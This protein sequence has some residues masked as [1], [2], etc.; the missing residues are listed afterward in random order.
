MVR[1][2]RPAFLLLENVPGL[3]SH[4]GGRTLNIILS[5]FHELGYGLEWCVL[6]SKNFCVPQERKRLYIV[7]NLGG[8]YTGKVFPLKN[9]NAEALKQLIGGSQGQRVYQTNGVSTCLTS[10]SGGWGYEK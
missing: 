10:N 4:D 1:V 5:A 6:N 2:K 7:G 9:G 8:E 3:L